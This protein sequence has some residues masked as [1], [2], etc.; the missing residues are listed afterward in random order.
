[1]FLRT[2]VSAGRRLIARIGAAAGISLL[3]VGTSGLLIEARAQTAPVS[4]TNFTV[5]AVADALSVEVNTGLLGNTFPL[6]PAGQPT[7]FSSS[8]SAQAVLD[9]LGNDSGFASAP[10]LGSFVNSLPGTV[11]GIG[12]PGAQPG[13]GAVPPLPAIPGIVTSSYPGSQS[14]QQIQGPFGISSQS[15]PNGTSADARIGLVSS[16]PSVVSS[17]ATSVARMDPSTGTMTAQADSALNSLRISDL[18]SLGDVTAHAKLTA[19]PGQPPAKES[20]F[21]IGL[22]IA[23][24]PVG[25]TDKGLVPGSGGVPGLDLSSL[26]KLLSAAGIGLQ[27]L[28]SKQTATSIDSAGLQITL[29]QTLPVQGPVNTVLTFGHVMASLV[30]GDVA[31]ASGGSADT[32]GGGGTGV[33][34]A[35]GD[36]GSPGKASSGSS[37]LATTGT[38]AG[39]TSSPVIA[40]A[41]AASGLG[42]TGA[43]P[44]LSH[45]TPRAANGN[46][47]FFQPIVGH[48]GSTVFLAL[49]GA[50]IAIMGA[51]IL[52]GG[53]GVKLFLPPAPG[54][55]SV[56]RL[57]P[58][59]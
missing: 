43:S 8:S 34:S 23:G 45:R 47:G 19:A 36:T 6:V 26:N 51:A 55:A 25:L 32:S 46:G 39:T 31:S 58:P 37:G 18:L 50:A 38:S 52:F 48:K 40:S 30:P 44:A 53:L 28:P 17:T 24:I 10:Y 29:N 11:N 7:D 5:T 20:S 59:S 2:R 27:F 41:P 22:T 1:V 57:P 35:G 14:A 13:I 16:G 9:S 56:L 4:P 54:G 49:T 42:R 21:H 3:M 12:V 33:G 15:D